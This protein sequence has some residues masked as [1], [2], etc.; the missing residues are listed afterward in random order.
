MP[1]KA[2][3]LKHA[4]Q[5]ALQGR[6]EEA[7]PLL[8][9]YADRADASSA[10]SLAEL[11]A[12]QGEWEECLKRAG[13]FIAQPQSVYAGNVF[14][15]MVGLLARAGRETDQWGLLLDLTQAAQQC[16]EENT[17]EY[18][19]SKREAA[20]TR[21]RTILQGLRLYA[22]GEDATPF[23]LTQIFGV[24][25]RIPAEQD[26]DYQFAK[27]NATQ[28][29][30]DLLNDPVALSRHLF[31]LA[32]FYHQESEG[33]RLYEAERM[34]AEFEGAVFVAKAYVRQGQAER[35]WEV[36]WRHMHRWWP[37]D[38]AQV[39]PVVLLIDRDLRALMNP[40]RCKKVLSLPRGPEDPNTGS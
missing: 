40:V 34:P 13:A 20:R 29:R 9:D 28:L 14:N 23:D 33:I 25:M 26:A 35:A 10:A 4:R 19:L 17:A 3:N 39:A 24:A 30:P 11:L 7:I 1:Y 12:F 22:Q 18:N 37:V 6:V 27:Q 36:L 8:R 15:D 2:P 21:Y 16:V 31:S 38:R 32:Q 5:M